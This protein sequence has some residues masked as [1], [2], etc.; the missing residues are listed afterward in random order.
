MLSKLKSGSLIRYLIFNIKIGFKNIALRV[1][2][3]TI[4]PFSKTKFQ[5]NEPTREGG[6]EGKREV[7]SFFFLAAHRIPG[8]LD[9]VWPTTEGSQLSSAELKNPDA[10][11]GMQQ[12]EQKPDFASPKKCLL[13]FDEGFQISKRQKKKI[14]AS[15]EK[16]STKKEEKVSVEDKDTAMYPVSL[17]GQE[18]ALLKTF[19]F[20]KIYDFID[21][22]V[23]IFPFPSAEAALT[24]ARLLETLQVSFSC[25]FS[26]DF[27]FANFLKFEKLYKEGIQ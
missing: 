16:R 11:E 3:A 10:Q 15:Q 25:P 19:H 2:K 27:V 4:V 7:C 18:K 23:R 6:F 21:N 17:L 14:L 12:A 20:S 1:S 24:F 9:H 5:N 22:T 13:D 26:E 8:W